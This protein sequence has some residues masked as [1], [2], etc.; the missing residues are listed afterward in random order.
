MSLAIA[1]LLASI[2][3]VIKGVG[4]AL[5]WAKGR[6]IE[7]Q[8]PFPSDLQRT[9][10][11]SV[12]KATGV[13][14]GMTRAQDLPGGDIYRNQIWKGVSQGMG[15]LREAG[16]GAVLSGVQ[17]LVGGAQDQFAGM[18]AGL[19]EQIERAK[20]G[21]TGALGAQGGYEA[22]AEDF[23]NQLA[24]R[25]YEQAAASSS[26]MKGAGISNLFNAASDIGGVGASAY[27]SKK[28]PDMMWN[29]NMGG[30][31]SY[32]HQMWGNQQYDNWVNQG[33]GSKTFNVPNITQGAQLGAAS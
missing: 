5:Q 24:L 30:G 1:A 17:G 19:M 11:E 15:A 23:K 3:S 12:K 33:G 22:D 10:P 21:Y 27:M 13:M 4:G 16:P 2:P 26:A 8:N 32:P 14:E 7:K 9:V 6:K 20:V 18:Q 25:Q 29:L 28:H 31:Q